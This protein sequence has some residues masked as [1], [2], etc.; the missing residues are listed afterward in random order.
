MNP[1][2]DELKAL[3]TILR[4]QLHQALDAACTGHAKVL[5]LEARL[6]Q[7]QPKDVENGE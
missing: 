3:V 1:E 7:S 6:A 5:V 2:I 4:Q